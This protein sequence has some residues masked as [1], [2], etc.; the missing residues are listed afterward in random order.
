LRLYCEATVR[1]RRDFECVY[2][3]PA[4]AWMHRMAAADGVP[5]G[6]VQEH[7][8]GNTWHMETVE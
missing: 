3:A 2:R 5:L 1:D 7:W 8:E 4:L 6:P